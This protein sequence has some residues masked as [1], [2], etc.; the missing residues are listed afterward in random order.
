[1]CTGQSVP[2]TTSFPIS[3]SRRFYLSRFQCYIPH[4]RP[5][6][7]IS[8]SNVARKCY[9]LPTPDLKEQVLTK[10]ALIYDVNRDQRQALVNTTVKDWGPY[11]VWHFL[12][13]WAT[14]RFSTRYCLRSAKIKIYWNVTSCSLVNVCQ[15]FAYHTPNTQH[16]VPSMD[17]YT[18]R[19]RKEAHGSPNSTP[20]SSH[21]TSPSTSLYCPLQLSSHSVH[22]NVH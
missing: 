1:V 4:Q 20:P 12:T 13:S 21:Y 15:Y 22:T 14:V 2:V 6:L 8:K 19:L 7:W 10:T 3:F 9:T 18:P 5:A 17:L 11:K 16:L